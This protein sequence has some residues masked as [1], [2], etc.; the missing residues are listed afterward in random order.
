MAEI[1]IDDIVPGGI[2]ATDHV[3]RETCDG[4]CSRCGEIVENDD[5]PLLLWLPPD[6]NDMLIYCT[7]CLDPDA[8]GSR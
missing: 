1:S 8:L 2:L 6:R 4:I 3:H 7:R 5:A